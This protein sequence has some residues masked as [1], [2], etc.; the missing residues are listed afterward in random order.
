MPRLCALALQY[1]GALAGPPKMCAT[2]AHFYETVTHY[3]GGKPISG[4]LCEQIGQVY[5][6]SNTC[7]SNL[8]SL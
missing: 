1:Y 7:R 5:S 6:H 3:F 8:Y 2:V 4:Q